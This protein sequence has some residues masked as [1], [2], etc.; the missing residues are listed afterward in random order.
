VLTDANDVLIGTWDNLT[1]INSNFINFYTQEEVQTA[2]AGQ[3]VF[4]LSSVTYTPGTNSLSVFVDGVNQYDGSSYAYVETDSTTV[5]FTAGLHVGALVKFTTAVTLSSGVTTADL[6]TYDP[7]F[8]ASVPTTVEL[9]LAETVSVKDFGAV[10]DGVTDD[11]DAIRAAVASVTAEGGQ[12]Y[13][14]A[15]SYK[16]TADPA[17]VTGNTAIY[18]PSKVRIYG[19]SQGGTLIV[20]GANNTVCFR[21]L[22]NNGGIENLQIDNLGTTYT[23]TSGIQ[24]APL[25]EAQTTIRTDTQFNEVTNVSI[26]RVAEAIVLRCGPTVGGADSYCYYNTFTNI[27]IRN[28]NIG[29]WLKI[30]NTVIGS[31]CNRNRFINC[32]VGETGCNTG[33]IIDA[34][35]TNTFVGLSFE[36]I[37][38]G[39]TPNAT[40]T[41]IV[42]AYNTLSYDAGENKFYGLSI[43]G[44]TRSINNSNPD[45]ELYGYT[46][47]TNSYFTPLNYPLAV[48]MTKGDIAGLRVGTNRQP[49][50]T[51]DFYVPSTP[52][53]VQATS[54]TSSSEI[55]VNSGGNFGYFSYYAADVPYWRMGNNGTGTTKITFFDGAFVARNVIDISNGNFYPSVDNTSSLGLATNRWSVVYAGTGAINTSDANQKTDIVDISEV[56][57]RVAIKLKSLIKRFKFKEG[58]RYHFGVIAQDVKTAFESEGLVAEEYGVFCSDT[59]EDGS[60]QLGVRY[61]ELLTFIISVM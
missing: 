50:S 34:G 60:I 20:P 3:T 1:G 24:L 16:V 45:L 55:R 35:N 25:D 29:I 49:T 32:R 10:G 9:K 58:K 18:V 53:L 36:G 44:C 57:K 2:T 40:P 6:V 48:N 4:T 61:D 56:E 42:V 33:L 59:L 23:N 26:R 7:P 11:S 43:E 15:G 22:G 39:P 19:A 13:F 12:V 51:G 5:T 31:G 41:A 38:E 27:D 52:S 47:A 8:I 17:D 30:P 54:G 46:D 37:T 14:P 21:F 28:C